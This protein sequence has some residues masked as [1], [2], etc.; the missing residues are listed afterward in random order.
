M[1]KSKDIINMMEMANL[2]PRNT[3][4][5]FFVW[6][7]EM[8]EYRKDKHSTPRIKLAKD[9]PKNVIAS[10][11]IN[12]NATVL[13]GNVEAGELTSVKK[14]VSLNYDL[15]IKHWKGDIDTFELFKKLQKV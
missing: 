8:G 2:R 10:V 11:S 15:L 12:K 7:D 4:L 1:S 5:S 13:T 6:V 3:G 9:T 14:W